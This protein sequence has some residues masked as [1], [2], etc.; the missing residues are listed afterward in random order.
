M[1]SRSS[2]R[3]GGS[4]SWVLSPRSPQSGSPAS[5][6]M[7][8]SSASCASRSGNN[9]RV[10]G[11]QAKRSR[12]PTTGTSCAESM[13]WPRRVDSI[14]RGI[15]VR[16]PDRGLSCLSFFSATS[17]RVP[18]LGVRAASDHAPAFGQGGS[19]SRARSA[20]QS[21][22]VIRRVVRPGHRALHPLGR[23]SGYGS[24]RVREPW[25]PGRP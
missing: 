8:G 6:G 25:D 24:V 16:A 10:G 23:S 3:L 19:S 2:A 12:P 22:V 7:F 18:N 20:K 21:A 13:R 5:A 9:A 11:H 15:A 1:V 14:A 17:E 4:H